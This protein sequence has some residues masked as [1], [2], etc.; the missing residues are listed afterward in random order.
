MKKITQS[1]QNKFAFIAITLLAA[2]LI[3]VGCKKNDN[4]P[5]SPKFENTTEVNADVQGQILGE[6]GKPLELAKVVIGNNSFTTDKN[7][8][9]I[10]KNIQTKK[11]ATK[12]TVTKDGY[13]AAYRTLYIKANTD[14]FTK[15]MVLKMD[16]PQNFSAGSG[17][18]IVAQGGASVSIP[19]NGIVQKAS[20]AP[21]NG[22]VTIYAK[23]IN[24][25]NANIAELT[26]GDLRGITTE[27]VE[28]ALE[29]YGMLAVEMFDNAGNE[30]QL[31]SGKPATIKMP[32]PANLTTTAPASIPL[33]HFDTDKGMWVEEGSATKQGNEYVGEVK[34]FSYW[35]CDYGGPIVQFDATIL[36]LNSNPIPNI[37]VKLT[38]SSNGARYSITNSAGYVSGGVPT[39]SSFTLELITNCGAFYSTTFSTTTSNVSLGNILVS[40]PITNTAIING[41]AVDCNGAAI[42]NATVIYLGSNTLITQANASGAFS[43]SALECNLPT[44]STV[45][46]YDAINNVNGS[47][48]PTINV[49]ANAVG[50]VAACGTLN[51]FFNYS[52]TDASGTY[53]FTNVE[54]TSNFNGN[55]NAPYTTLGASMQGGQVGTNNYQNASL[56]FN[57]AGSTGTYDLYSFSHYGFANGTTT[58]CYSDSVSVPTAIGVPVTITQYASTIGGFIE[59]NYSGSFTNTQLSPATTYTISGS[60]RNKRTW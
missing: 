57:G 12:I 28:N 13:F 31:A 21:Y 16:N 47:V 48:S 33:W 25:D 41:T 58:F 51:Q 49:G 34:H 42:P 50:N 19:A 9:F 46:A 40:L 55:Y 44:T 26:P 1:P 53:A 30:L 38:S 45:T 27:N 2:V 6:D 14:N 59:G 7:G 11:H 3:M 29:T 32:I 23:T 52:Y 18:S 17:A 22:T 10:F 60:F 37:Q 20:N 43:F 15:I 54:P 56:I 5:N 24:A 4:G 35:N 36:D 39:N 8:I